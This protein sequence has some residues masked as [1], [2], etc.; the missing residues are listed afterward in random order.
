MRNKCF[1]KQIN[2]PTT[3]RIPVNECLFVL[4]VCKIVDIFLFPSGKDDLDCKLQ[5]TLATWK[6]T[7]QNVIGINSKKI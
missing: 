2:K 6:T 7:N 5:Q 1:Y 3:R 4:S